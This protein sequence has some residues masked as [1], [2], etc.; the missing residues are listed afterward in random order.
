M[1]YLAVDLKNEDSFRA[2]QELRSR[3]RVLSSMMAVFIAYALRR[4]GKTIYPK[5]Q[6]SRDIVVNLFNSSFSQITS[7]K[8]GKLEGGNVEIELVRF[9]PP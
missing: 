9:I 8:A 3:L 5:V 2:L 7:L 4:G 6:S 1:S